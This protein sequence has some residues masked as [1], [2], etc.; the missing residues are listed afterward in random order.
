MG[1]KVAHSLEISDFKSPEI[2]ERKFRM[3]WPGLVEQTSKRARSHHGKFTIHKR[4]DKSPESPST[5]HNRREIVVYTH[6]LRYIHCSCLDMRAGF[7]EPN[8]T[9][10]RS[11]VVFFFSDSGCECVRYVR[12]VEARARV[13][14]YEKTPI[15]KSVEIKIYK[16]NCCLL[17]IRIFWFQQVYAFYFLQSMGI[18]CLSF[19]LLFRLLLFARL[20]IAIRSRRYTSRLVLLL[21]VCVLYVHLLFEHLLVLILENT[22]YTQTRTHRNTNILELCVEYFAASIFD[23][24][25]C[26]FEL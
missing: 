5:D 19:S 9:A 21:C 1:T 11:S 25:I 17:S 3:T 14:V 2:G 15:I 13:F 23:S 18:E 26:A 10:Q 20:R 16:Y 4:R 22:T 12:S 24:I 8:H 6:C 7:A